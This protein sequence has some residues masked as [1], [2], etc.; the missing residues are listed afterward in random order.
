M[1]HATSSWDADEGRMLHGFLLEPEPALLAPG[2]L[3]VEAG[4]VVR[5][6]SQEGALSRSRAEAALADLL[7]LGV[8]EMH[9]EPLLVRVWQLRD[10]FTIDDGVF[11]ALA[12]VTAQPLLT[13]DVRLAGAARR[14][15]GVE[16]LTHHDAQPGG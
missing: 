5:P 4:R 8:E 7:D 9:V 2:T 1:V 11:V 10:S 12:E 15:T 16:I 6:E 14:R 13:T 3:W